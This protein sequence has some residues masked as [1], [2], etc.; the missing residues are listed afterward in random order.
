MGSDFSFQFLFLLA[1]F[2]NSSV[3]LLPKYI[4]INYQS[5]QFSGTSINVSV[6]KFMFIYINVSDVVSWLLTMQGCQK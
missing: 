6:F 1:I 2:W 4:F 3:Y 5:N